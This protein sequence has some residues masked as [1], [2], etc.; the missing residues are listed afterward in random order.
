MT[1]CRCSRTG[2]AVTSLAA[3]QASPATLGEAIRGH[4]TVKNRLP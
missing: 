2:Y 4:W 1:R 3:H